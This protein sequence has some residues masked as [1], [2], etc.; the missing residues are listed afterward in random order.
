[1]ASSDSDMRRILE[2]VGVENSVISNFEA[3]FITTEKVPMLTDFQ[4]FLLGLKTFEKREL[5]RSCCTKYS[6]SGDA[7]K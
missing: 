3:H 1:M 2:S 5:I 7:G 6:N 4:L